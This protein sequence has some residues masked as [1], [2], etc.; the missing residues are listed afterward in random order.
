MRLSRFA[1][2]L[3]AF[4]A[5]LSAAPSIGAAT[6]TE[7][8]ERLLP[9]DTLFYV[10]APRLG[11]TLDALAERIEG[12]LQNDSGGAQ[13]ILRAFGFR[14]PPLPALETPDIVTLSNV[15]QVLGCDPMGSGGFALIGSVRMAGRDPVVLVVLPTRNPDIVWDSVLAN[16]APEF[17]KQTGALCRAQMREIEEAKR[18]R[19]LLHPEANEAPTLEALQASDPQTPRMRCPCGGEYA[20]GAK[21]QPCECSIHTRREMGPWP[22][23]TKEALPRRQMGAATVVGGYEQGF[24]YACTA[25]HVIIS[26]HPDAVLRAVA[27]LNGTGTKAGLTA[28]GATFD[29]APIRV[30]FNSPSLMSLLL[31]ELV[32]D[33]RRGRG[34]PP[35]LA[36]QRVKDLFDS[37]GPAT[38]D[39]LM[40]PDGAD[41]RAVVT[42]RDGEAVHPILAT[43]PDQLS[44]LRF[45]P[46]TALCAF[47]SNLVR[48]G[49]SVLG[50]IAMTDE[51]EAGMTFKYFSM[52]LSPDGAFAFLPGS[53]DPRGEIPHMLIV[54]RIQNE[55]TYNQLQVMLLALLMGRRGGAPEVTR[56]DGAEVRTIRVGGGPPGEGPSFH[57]T[58]L[59]EYVVVCTDLDGLKDVIRRGGAEETR[60]RRA[61]AANFAATCDFPALFDTI[62]SGEEE[63]RNQ[64]AM[65]NCAENMAP[66]NAL[67][68]DFKEATGR[69]PADMEELTK[70]AQAHNKPTRA[71]RCPLGSPYTIDPQTGQAVCAAH[72]TADAPHIAAGRENRS[73]AMTKPLGAELGKASLLLQ[74][75]NGKAMI[76][77][78][79]RGRIADRD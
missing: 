45:V 53:M 5:L 42:M 74:F 19:F 78:G 31:R 71:T 46:D 32:R 6:T 66:I 2:G 72:G 29:E 27:A 43:P 63:R 14:K 59:G 41:F 69:T 65:R 8:I 26:N 1:L 30:Y 79:I 49:M 21:E 58:R 34:D 35:S 38:A 50:D 39:V 75:E 20:V 76:E 61:P 73:A 48:H 40:R 37:V 54:S 3:V 57:W 33:F 60:L 55:E 24:A 25:D 56:S 13:G 51:F 18:N 16:L 7:D 44:S 47:G 68:T 28:T 23:I 22:A 11:Q 9:D 17:Q 4:C 15:L 52:S 70:F 12:V 77:G 67:I 10:G 62:I 36:A 64:W